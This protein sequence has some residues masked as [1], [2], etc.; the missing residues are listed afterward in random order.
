[1]KVARWRKQMVKTLETAPKRI[2]NL[3]SMYSERDYKSDQ[4][5][6]LPMIDAAPHGAS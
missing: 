6:F 1:M 3:G 2:E 4:K 5:I